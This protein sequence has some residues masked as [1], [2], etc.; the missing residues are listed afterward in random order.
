MLS[1]VKFDEPIWCIILAKSTV[2]IRVLYSFLG[3]ANCTMSVPGFIITQ[4]VFSTLQI[5]CAVPIHPFPLLWQHWSFHSLYIFRFLKC[6]KGGI[7]LCVTFPEWLH[8][9]SNVQLSFLYVW[10]CFIL[11]WLSTYTSSFTRFEF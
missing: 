11:L 2:Y 4:N 3:F 5:P 9:L 7:I 8:S 10:C 6:P 1:Y